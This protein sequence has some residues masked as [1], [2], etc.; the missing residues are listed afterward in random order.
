VDGGLPT[1][2]PEDWPDLS[3]V[4]EYVDHVRDTLDDAIAEAIHDH[5]ARNREFPL[6]QLLHVAL[7]HRLMHAETLAYMFHQLPLDQK[8]KPTLEPE[9][10]GGP[11][12]AQIRRI[13]AGKATLGLRRS[14]SI[15]GWDNEYEQHIVEVP[16]FEIDRYPV[17]NEQFLAF[18]G[19]GGYQDRAY[20]SEADWNWVTT[21][22]INCPG[23][24]RHRAQSWYLRTMFDEIPLPADWPVYVS[25]AEACAFARWAKKALPGEA[26]WH[27]TA[28]GT[29]DGA[30]R[31]YPW[32]SAAPS[33]RY[34]NFDF[35]RWDPTPVNAHPGGDSAF[36]VADLTGNGWEWTSSEFGPFPGFEPFAFYRGYSADF[37]DHRHFVMKGGSTR[38]AACMLRRSFRNWFQAHYPYVYAG[39]RCVTQ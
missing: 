1:D 34:G 36:G 24:W 5:G 38:T 27:R 28:Y 30:E 39:F 37:F 26:Q 9:R 19:A 15:F 14:D 32:G 20:W 8:I 11:V 4:R 3:Q 7:E 35:E 10:T 2:Q 16:A 25:H 29:P 6:E 21:N 23:F 12:Q 31:S 22:K 18:V 17:T 33:S 13:P